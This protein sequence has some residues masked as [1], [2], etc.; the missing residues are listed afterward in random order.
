MVIFA[1]EDESVVTQLKLIK[2]GTSFGECVGYCISEVEINASAVSKT[3]YGWNNS[4]TPKTEVL[5]Y[6][7]VQFLALVDKI[8]QDKFLS[9]DPVIGCPDCADGG[10]EWIELEIDGR[11]KKVTFE[12]GSSPDG[13]KEVL[14]KL[15]RL[16]K[17]MLE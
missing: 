15:R 1:C 14:Q 7:R 11:L 8:D 6:R 2:Y 17:P 4:M 9:L 13:L 10:S 12:Y 5:Q 3:Q 16:D